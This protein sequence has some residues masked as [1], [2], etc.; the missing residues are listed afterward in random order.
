MILLEHCVYYTKCS[1]YV[2][3]TKIY[4]IAICNTSVNSIYFA[5]NEDIFNK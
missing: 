3:T 5:R 2:K 1:F 4:V